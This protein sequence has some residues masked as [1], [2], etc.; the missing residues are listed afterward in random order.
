MRSNEETASKVAAE[1]S[2]SPNVSLLTPSGDDGGPVS[3]SVSS[4]RELR[5]DAEILAISRALEYAGWNRRRAAQL[6]RISYRGLLYKIRK[7]NLS[8]AQ[9]SA[10]AAASELQKID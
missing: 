4:L 8:T 7:Y 3:A 9:T 5:E 10:L 6:L 1:D 2:G